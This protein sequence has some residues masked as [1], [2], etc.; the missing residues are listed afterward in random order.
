MTTA[1]ELFRHV[2]VRYGGA[3]SWGDEVPLAGRGVYVVSTNM[4]PN[5][6]GLAECPL[7][8][9]AVTSLLEVRPEATVDG[10]RADAQKVA[11]RLRAMWPAREPV[12]YI[13]LAGTSTR[14]RV[15]QFYETSIG[16]RG[17]HAGGWPVKMLETA[18]LWVHYGRAD[19]PAT[20]EAAMV[21]RFVE[22]L[23]GDVCRALIDPAT[24]LPFANLTFPEGRRKNHG[25]R[26]VKA[27]RNVSSRGDQVDQSFGSTI[28]AVTD[29]ATVV[30][31]SRRTQDLTDADLAAG[32]IRI[33]LESKSLFPK[34]KFEIRVELGGEIHVAS[35]DPRKAGDKERSGVIRI[36]REV[37]TQHMSAGRLRIVEVTGGGFRIL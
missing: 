8:L 20:A 34:S 12:V 27:P 5:G 7:D 24:P 31:G 33:P 11:N 36:G 25:F 32:Q 21:D 15:S 13:G 30:T 14:Q 29:A 10:D 2:G 3:V 23:P 37:L 35:W 22:G 26:G 28:P 9:A 17:P 6:T 19:A 18:R 4:N 16:A 1:H